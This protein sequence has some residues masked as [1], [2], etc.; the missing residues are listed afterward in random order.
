M[1]ENVETTG[2]TQEETTPV[3]TPE[4]LK[5]KPVSYV[6]KAKGYFTVINI[7][8][9]EKVIDFRSNGACA[10]YTA[11]TPKEVREIES[12]DQFD[13]TFFKVFDDKDIPSG[14]TNVKVKVGAR[15]VLKGD[16]PSPQSP[17]DMQLQKIIELSKLNGGR[18]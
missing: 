9:R 3:V 11:T 1:L 16:I 13:K 18:A 2:A 12:S 17:I 10:V 14:N 15:S 8:G 4:Q 7:K 5:F 6:A